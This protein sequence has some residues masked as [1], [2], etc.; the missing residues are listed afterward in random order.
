MSLRSKRSSPPQST[1]SSALATAS[2][3]KVKASYPSTHTLAGPINS[4][5]DCRLRQQP[6]IISVINMGI[7][8]DMIY[9]GGLVRLDRDIIQRHGVAYLMILMGVNDLNHH[10]NTTKGQAACYDHLIFAFSQFIDRAHEA[11]LPVFISTILPYLVPPEFVPH[12]GT[13]R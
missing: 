4:L 8:G 7:S 5:V 6:R 1:P 10:P 3:I 11:G 13:R 9:E 12:P 2:Q